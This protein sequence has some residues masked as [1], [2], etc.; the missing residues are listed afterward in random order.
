MKSYILFLPT[1]I[2]DSDGYEFTIVSLDNKQWQFEAPTQDVSS[3]FKFKFNFAGWTIFYI[4]IFCVKLNFLLGALYKSVPI[5]FN[6]W[7]KIDQM[8]CEN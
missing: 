2:L 8:L 6:W 7:H 4:F 3:K 1:F 5:L